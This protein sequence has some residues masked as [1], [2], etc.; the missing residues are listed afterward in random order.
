MSENFPRG[1]AIRRVN[2]EP[3]IM[4]GSGRALL[5]QIAHPHVAAGVDEHSDFQSNPF[6]RLQGTLESVYSMV[7]GDEELATGIGRR[8][9]WIHQF[10][11]G[12]GYQANDPSALLWVHATLLDSALSCYERLVEPLSVDDVEA[13]YQEM[14]RVAEA[15]GCPRDAQPATYDDFRAYWD[16]EV[17]TMQVTD[18]GRTLARD[19]LRPKLPLRLDA[20]LSPALALFRLVTVGTLPPAIRDGFQLPWSAQQQRRLDRVHAVARRTFQ[21]LP[22]AAR[23]GPVHLNGRLLLWQAARHVAQFEAKHPEVVAA[24]A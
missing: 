13:Y 3:A 15:F 16:D 14:T 18:T 23:V 4:F 10:V 22:R 1:S 20:P 8:V 5:L 2:A 19:I 12:A 9:H 7:Y 6:K 21:V 24:A 11:T 17:A